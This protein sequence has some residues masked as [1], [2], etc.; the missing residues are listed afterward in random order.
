MD[1]LKLAEVKSENDKFQL[2]PSFEKTNYPGSKY[3]GKKG[4]KKPYFIKQNGDKFSLLQMGVR[5]ALV[6]PC[7]EEHMYFAAMN[8]DC[9]QLTDL[10]K[11]YYILYKKNIF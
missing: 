6:R 1:S 10:G 9:C 5:N 11:H 8:S 7:K 2:G 3:A 4:L